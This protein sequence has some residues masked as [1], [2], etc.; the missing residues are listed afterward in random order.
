MRNENMTSRFKVPIIP[1]KE[2]TGNPMV[3]LSTSSYNQPFQS[4]LIASLMQDIIWNDQ[5]DETK[6]SNWQL[7]HDN[8]F[9]Q[10]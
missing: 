3:N 5:N 2:D 6:T 7:K 1:Y 10:Y 4:V 9:S 8:L